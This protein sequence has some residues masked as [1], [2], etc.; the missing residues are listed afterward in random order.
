MIENLTVNSSV[1][2]IN[3]AGA[4][5]SH[6]STHKGLLDLPTTIYDFT[7]GSFELNE[8]TSVSAGMG[9]YLKDKNN[10]LFFIFSDPQQAN[11]SFMVEF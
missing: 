10:N 9:G 8:D 7:D 3:P 4:I 1:W 11:S 5:L 2:D 6:H